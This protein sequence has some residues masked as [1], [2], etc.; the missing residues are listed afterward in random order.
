MSNYVVQIDSDISG[1]I[2]LLHSKGSILKTES[3]FTFKDGILH[4][5]TLEADTIISRSD[6]RFKENVGNIQNCLEKLNKLQAKCYNYDSKKDEKRFGYIAQEV[7]EII[8]TVIRHDD[9]GMMYV[10]YVEIIPLITESIKEL[11]N[12]TTSLIEERNLKN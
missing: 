5:P 2:E 6:E 9:N 10:N 12:L 1:P 4:V 8:P 11:Y 3:N 7:N